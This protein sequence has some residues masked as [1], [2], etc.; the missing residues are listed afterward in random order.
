M[1]RWV[2]VSIAL[3]VLA[4]A[5]SFY[6]YQFQYD[7]LPAEVPT[8]W[9]WEG[10][11][12]QWTP[13][14][15]LW[16]NLL[17]VPAM[18]LVVV[19]LHWVLPWLS[20][21]AFQVSEFANVFHYIM[22]LVCAMM[23]YLQF[24]ILFGSLD[25]GFALARWMVG[26]IFFFLMLLGNVLGKTKKNFY[27]GIRTPWTLASDRVWADT[28]RLAAWL[29]VG[30][31]ATAMVLILLG[32]PLIWCTLFFIPIVY[33]ALHSLILYKRLERQGKLETQATN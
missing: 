9:D 26:G 20:P 10:Q 12:D 15:D 32:V 6:V 30:T 27:V 18:M 3:T 23:L 5:G 33:P 25:P 13:K 14:D 4:L 21:R 24:V 17:I 22:A 7:A 11:A 31:G 29:M 16:R 1:T 8:H 2:I 19:S 28:H